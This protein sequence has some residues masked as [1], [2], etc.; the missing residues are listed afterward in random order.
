MDPRFQ[1]PFTALISGPTGS[2]KTEWVKRFIRNIASVMSPVPDEIIWFYGAWQKGYEELTQSVTFIEGIPTMHDWDTKTK[3]LVIIDDLMHEAN[4]QVTKLFTKGSHHQNISVIYL[5]QNLF[6]K[7]KEQRTIS[8]NSHYMVLFKNPRDASQITHLA[9]QMY[10]KN[11]KFV[12]EA[13]KSATEE[14]YGYLLIDLRQETPDHLRLRSTI[15]PPEF[16]T[17]YVQK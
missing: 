1:H 10:P 13:F 12:Q 2:G 3:R 11:T 14:A 8:L 7:N 9:K 6:N 15:F 17:V 16:Q 4:D 5:V